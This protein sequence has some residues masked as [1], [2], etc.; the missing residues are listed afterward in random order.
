MTGIPRLRDYHGPQRMDHQFDPYFTLRP[1]LRFSALF[2]FQKNALPCRL[3][4][5]VTFSSDGQEVVMS[6]W[7]LTRILIAEFSDPLGT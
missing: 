7:F 3:P 1:S 2:S 5:A 6:P 4:D